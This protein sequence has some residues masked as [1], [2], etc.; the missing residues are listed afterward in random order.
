MGSRSL[1]SIILFKL[2][3]QPVGLQIVVYL[4]P[5]VAVPVEIGNEQFRGFILPVLTRPQT[6]PFP[7]LRPISRA[8]PEPAASRAAPLQDRR[9]KNTS[10]THRL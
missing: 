1:E 4:T 9:V 2:I 6:L 3:D 8:D 10:G 5:W 7:G